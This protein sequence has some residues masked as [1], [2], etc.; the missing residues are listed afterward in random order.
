MATLVTVVATPSEA[1]YVLTYAAMRYFE[2]CT[3]HYKASLRFIYHI[4]IYIF[5]FIYIYIYIYI[6]VPLKLI[7]MCM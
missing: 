7:C 5:I 3:Q 2:A 4:Y 6:Q 1:C